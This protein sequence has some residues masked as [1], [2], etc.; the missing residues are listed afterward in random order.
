[1]KGKRLIGF[2]TSVCLI[3]G[4]IQPAISLKAEG[5]TD[6]METGTLPFTEDFEDAEK[7][8]SRWN[9]GSDITIN[10]AGQALLG[11]KGEAYSKVYLTGVS[12]T[13]KWS[14]YIYMDNAC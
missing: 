1:M 9:V 3:A 7:V 11:D 14:N 4:M 5:A 8:A 10:T 2:I 13:D 12:D 6:V